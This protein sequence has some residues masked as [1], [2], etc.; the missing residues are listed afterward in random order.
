MTTIRSQLRTWGSLRLNRNS[1]RSSP[2]ADR[3]VQSVSIP[4]EGVSRPIVVKV[5]STHAEWQAAFRLVREN[6]DECGYEPPSTKLLRFTPYHALPDTTVFIAKAAGDVVATFT[7][8][9]DNRPLGLPLEG[10]Y[11]EEVKQLRNQGRRIAE[12]TSLAANRIT[13]R[14]FVHVYEAMIRLNMQYHVH[15]GGDTWVLTVNPRHS[16]FYQRALGCLP[17][18]PRR[19]YQAVQGHPAEAFWLDCDL[20]KSNAPEM[21][22]KVFGEPISPD[23]LRA[24]QMPID[25]IRCLAAQSSVWNALDVEQTLG[26]IAR[27]GNPR[28]W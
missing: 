14:E 17:L 28:C 3:I 4:V 6:Y 26:L 15:H 21:Y 16:M 9:P 25:T 2:R 8:V 7:L 24:R 11:E 5:A 1:K 19:S 18:G 23:V 13:Q 12:V 20:M 27:T 10:L 22:T